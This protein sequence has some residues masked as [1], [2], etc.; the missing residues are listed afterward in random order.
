MQIKGF[1]T[2]K[3]ASDRLKMQPATIRRYC[4]RGV[5]ASERIG[6]T[7]LIST[8]ELAKFKAIRRK[9]GRPKTEKPKKTASC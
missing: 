2:I 1:L 7:V 9:P 5:I 6:W 8:Q 3:Q 4:S